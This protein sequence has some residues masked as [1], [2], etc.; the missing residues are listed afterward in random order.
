MSD[1]T[2]AVDLDHSLDV[3]SYVTAEVTLYLVVS[4]DLITKLC[5]VCIGKILCTSVGIDSGCYEDIICALSANTVNIGEGDFNAL[6]IRNI[7]TSYTS[8]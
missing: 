1:T 4:F 3:K 7:N 5:Y 2:V 8:H 6:V